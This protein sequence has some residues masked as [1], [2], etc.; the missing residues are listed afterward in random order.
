VKAQKKMNYELLLDAIITLAIDDE[1]ICESIYNAVLAQ[2][3]V[4]S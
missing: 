2:F 1:S 3:E 4:K